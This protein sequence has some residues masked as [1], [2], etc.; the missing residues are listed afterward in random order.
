MRTTNVFT[1]LSMF[2][3]VVVFMQVEL[4]DR[5][6]EAVRTG[7]SLCHQMIMG[8]GKTTVVAP[9]LALILADGKRLVCQVSAHHKKPTDQH[10]L[11]FGHFSGHFSGHKNTGS[12]RGLV[13][14]T[15]GLRER[16][17]WGVSG[18]LSAPLPLFAQ[19]DP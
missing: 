8:A 18:V 1:H 12:A 5:F 16:S 2:V 15:Q 3:T 19:E 9:L 7:K 17:I 14:F 4:I 6:L 13:G 11:T 10:Q